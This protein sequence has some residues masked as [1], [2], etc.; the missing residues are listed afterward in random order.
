MSS[1]ISVIRLCFLTKRKN[2]LDMPCRWK[3]RS[4]ALNI[5]HIL[6]MLC[7][8]AVRLKVLY[9]WIVYFLKRKQKKRLAGWKKWGWKE[10]N[11][12][13]I[14]A[15]V[16]HRL[17]FPLLT[18]FCKMWQKKHCKAKEQRDEHGACQTTKLKEGSA[19]FQGWYAKV[20]FP[21]P[22]WRLSGPIGTPQ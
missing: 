22:N 18:L 3:L 12:Q 6:K 5:D 11:L 1:K 8:K 4:F 2:P 10:G 15:Q 13:V 20:Q 19:V 16:T 9:K 17:S 21:F 14:V 7:N